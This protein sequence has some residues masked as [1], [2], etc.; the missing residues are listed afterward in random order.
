MSRNWVWVIWWASLIVCPLAMFLI[1]E[2]FEG[3]YN[4][5]DSY[6]KPPDPLG[7]RLINPLIITHFFLTSLCVMAVF[8][9][10]KEWAR[11]YVT[12]LG[13]LV[14]L[15]LAAYA[16]LHTWTKVGSMSL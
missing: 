9:L 11:R 1:G 13:V 6:G 15:L 10:L 7:I 12:C 4:G 14:M 5:F 8:R 3:K 16:W 2:V